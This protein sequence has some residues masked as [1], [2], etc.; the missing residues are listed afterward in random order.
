MGCFGDSATLLLVEP[1]PV[2]AKDVN[3]SV[4][5]KSFFI[6]HLVSNRQETA[7]RPANRPGGH[8]AIQR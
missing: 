4:S 1:Q 8:T 3:I 7:L 2:M 5:G 6:F